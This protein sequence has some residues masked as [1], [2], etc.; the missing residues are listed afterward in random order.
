MQSHDL[1]SA[2]PPAATVDSAPR[3]PRIVPSNPQLGPTLVFSRAESSKTLAAHREPVVATEK[4][5]ERG[6][7]GYFDNMRFQLIFST[8]KGFLKFNLH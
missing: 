6:E 3:P 8:L 2:P 4:E 5:G 7:L 1:S